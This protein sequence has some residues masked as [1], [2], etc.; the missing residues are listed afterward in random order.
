[1]ENRKR[2]IDKISDEIILIEDEELL[3]LCSPSS[4]S[5]LH[6]I[7]DP[8]N[9]LEEVANN[10]T[11]STREEMYHIENEDRKE[12]LLIQHNYTNTNNNND[13]DLSLS[14]VDPFADSISQHLLSIPS[15]TLSLPPFPTLTLA[16]QVDG[17]LSEKLLSYL[18]GKLSQ[19][20]HTL[21]QQYPY[22]V[23]RYQPDELGRHFLNLLLHDEKSLLLVGQQ[24]N[25]V[26]MIG[27]QQLSPQ[28]SNHSLSKAGNDFSR[29]L[30]RIPPDMVERL[31]LLDRND[32]IH[33]VLT[34]YY[35]YLDVG[36]QVYS[37]IQQQ[38]RAVAE[39]DWSQ[40]TA[41]QEALVTYKNAANAMGRKVWVL[42]ANRW[43]ADY[44][45]RF[46]C[47]GGAARHYRK[48]H[49]KT[50]QGLITELCNTADRKIRLLDVG[51]CYNPLARLSSVSNY[52]DITALDLCPGD[53]S[54]FKA[55][56]LDVS[57]L[58]ATNYQA[59][60]RV[61][62]EKTMAWSPEG[63]A[64]LSGLT[65]GAFDAVTMSLVLSYL[66]NPTVREAMIY[67][68]KQLLVS[69]GSVGRAPHHTGLLVIVEK[70]S[71][72]QMSDRRSKRSNP[73][74]VDRAVATVEAWKE[75]I[76]GMGFSLLAYQPLPASD[77]RKSHAFVF[78]NTSEPAK[79][80]EDPSGIVATTATSQVQAS[81]SDSN[82]NDAALNAPPPPN[83]RL[84]IKHDSLQFHHTAATAGK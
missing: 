38:H 30:T 62:L 80:M 19:A 14:N 46:F 21:S 44:C 13:D 2:P 29:A 51:S 68:A 67:K 1:M 83:P 18:E 52:F 31:F 73:S 47:Q 15:M 20:F 53:D 23:E 22:L 81:G 66:P 10:T 79:L 84:W 33:E 26:M 35:G 58:P 11:T 16:Q 40:I 65:A 72:L 4:S 64:E 28:W 24:S 42:E 70:Q 17:G 9:L 37:N 78:A 36:R 34:W 6:H 74:G 7:S 5:A 75:T 27:G 39:T 56:F 59:D 82:S 12:E 8:L 50:A 57:V 41:N 77:G 25:D 48:T 45:I 61:V 69:P 76:S 60:G 71:I 54:V 3:L 55:D 32:S 43:M 49:A 63:Q